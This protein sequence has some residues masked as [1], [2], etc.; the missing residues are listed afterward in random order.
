MPKIRILTGTVCGGKPINANKVVD[1][2]DRD[3]KLLIAMGRAEAV[4]AKG[5]SK[6]NDAP[7]PENKAEGLTTESAAG[8]VQR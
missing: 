5:K 6:A 1:A 2:N 8:I 3:A 7:A 4:K